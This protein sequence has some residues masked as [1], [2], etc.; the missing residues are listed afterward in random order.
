MR[1]KVIQ[2]AESTQLISLPRK[3]C[4]ARGIKKGDE[5]NIDFHGDKLLV[6][7]ENLP[8]TE[9]IEVDVSKLDRT[10]IMFFIRA[11]YKKGYDEIK[12]NFAKSTAFHYRTDQEANMSSIVHREVSRCPG[13]E[14]I[15][16]KENHCILKA[17]STADPKELDNILRRTFILISDTCKDLVTA[18]KN[19]DRV[20]LES[21]EEKHDNVT[22]FINH[23]CRLINKRHEDERK[24]SHFLFNIVSM[25]DK[26]LDI[27]KNASR[28][29][30]RYGKKITPD[31][32]KILD[33]IYESYE[34][35]HDL[36]YRFSFD[37]VHKMNELKEKTYRTILEKAKNIPKEEILLLYDMD[38]SLELYRALT[39]AR[40]AIQF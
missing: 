15:E 36:F 12:V 25:L 5:L 9:K 10:S 39:E 2:I 16:Q 1:R 37:K 40:M 6:G 32:S 31:S 33:M 38:Q 11:L 4:I 26:I 8:P 29:M 22:R 20:L 35:F 17:I 3:W 13:L 28:D 7:T 23:C 34:T 24:N 14:V 30:L 27:M 21:I 19:N 18:C